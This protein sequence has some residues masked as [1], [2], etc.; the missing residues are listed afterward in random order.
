MAKR[1]LATLF[2][3]ALLSGIAAQASANVTLTG[4]DVRGPTGTVWDTSPGGY[5][6][7]WVG[8][9][10]PTDTAI[11]FNAASGSGNSFDILGEG[12][13]GGQSGNSDPNYTLTLYFNDGSTD[14]S[15]AGL[16]NADTNSFAGPVSGNGVTL[17]AFSW[18]RD[19]GQQVGANTRVATGSDPLD[20]AGSFAFS[21]AAVPEPAQ[22]AMMLAGFGV[23]GAAARRRARSRQAMVASETRRW[24]RN[25]KRVGSATLRIETH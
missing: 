11:T 18:E 17:T 2:G 21:V 5:Y 3:A 15:L 16:Y 24:A 4:A 10:N 23:I 14:F 20:Y 9:L 8:S 1:V 12:W 25:S 22:W 7:L 13:V 19:A 6:A